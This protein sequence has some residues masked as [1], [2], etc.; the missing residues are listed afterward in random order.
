MGLGLAMVAT[1]VWGV[2]GTCR[3]YNRQDGQGIVVELVL[4]LAKDK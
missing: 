3:A 1:L 2:G 4:P